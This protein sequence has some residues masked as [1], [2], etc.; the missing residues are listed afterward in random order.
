M[1]FE[2]IQ[3]LEVKENYF[4]R[5]PFFENHYSKSQISFLIKHFGG[6]IIIPKIKNINDLDIIKSLNST[7]VDLSAILLVENPKCF[8]NLKEILD[9]YEAIINAVGFGSHDFCT[10]MQMKH[11]QE[12]LKNYKKQLI[13]LTKAYGKSYI[14]TVDLNL[15]DFSNFLD[16]CVYAFEN[17]ADSKFIIHPSQLDQMKLA[18]YFS[19]DEMN[20]MKKVFNIIQSYGDNDIDVFTVDGV[21]YEKPHVQRITDIFQKLNL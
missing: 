3:K 12:T 13:L 16:E 21:V 1:A 18:V 9:K 19:D 11:N 17:G 6:R 4:V 15:K 14:D 7:Q 2:N 20:Q 10:S 8:I 5:V